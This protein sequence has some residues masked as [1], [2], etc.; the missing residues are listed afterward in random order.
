MSGLTLDD[1]I[2]NPLLLWLGPIGREVP[3]HWLIDL[4]Q[5]C[6]LIH[7]VEFVLVDKLV[8]ASAELSNR[9]IVLIQ[10]GNVA[11]T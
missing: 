1:C 11:V 8:I 7:N 4:N 3:G 9:F 2:D 10:K 6:L 5:S